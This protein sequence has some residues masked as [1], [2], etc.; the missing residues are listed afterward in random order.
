MDV[1]YHYMAH[2]NI[3]LCPSFYS[4]VRDDVAQLKMQVKFSVS[5]YVA[6]A[7][8]LC[9]GQYLIPRDYTSVTLVVV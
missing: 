5:V 1:K 8:V 9:S 6:A 3:K 2:K 4:C 7:V